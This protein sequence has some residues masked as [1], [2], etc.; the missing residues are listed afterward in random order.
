[1]R[2]PLGFGGG[3]AGEGLVLAGFGEAACLNGGEQGRV[4]GG[5]QDMGGYDCGD[6][7]LNGGAERDKLGSVQRGVGAAK[8]EQGEVGAGVAACCGPSTAWS[9]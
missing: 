2:Q 5:E 8:G 3:D 6:A 1:M 7:G 4:K 9:R